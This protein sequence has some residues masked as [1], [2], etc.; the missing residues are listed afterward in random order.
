MKKASINEVLPLIELHNGNIS[1]IAR[2]LGVS[3]VTIYK[4]ISESRQLADA[5]ND[6][7]QTFVDEVESALYNNALEGN[8]TAQIFILKAHP[9]AKE[10]GWSERSELTG[11][12]GGAL[13]VEYV[14]DWRHTD[15]Q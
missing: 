11:R 2:H 14:N 15:I 10:R 9:I 4:R 1:A 5:L 8:V 12:D 7:R 13:R 3:R 6:A